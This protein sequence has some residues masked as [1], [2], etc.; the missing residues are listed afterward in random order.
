MKEGKKLKDTE[1]QEGET[2]LTGSL[3]QLFFS[4]LPHLIADVP[5]FLLWGEPHFE[6]NPLFKKLLPYTTRLIFQA[7]CVQAKRAKEMLDL[8]QQMPI[9]LVDLNWARLSA[10]RDVF[11]RVFDTKDQVRK[12]MAAESITIEYREPVVRATYLKGWLEAQAGLR[13]KVELKKSENT[14]IP[15][16]EIAKVICQLEPGVDI[17]MERKGQDSQV[18]IQTTLQEICKLPYM[19]PLLDFSSSLTFMK[20]LFYYPYGQHYKNTLGAIASHEAD[21]CQE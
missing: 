4:T 16:G 5:I 7:D 6:D 19:I 15:D 11:S 21:V 8:M 20:E 9:E 17:K 12:L 10:W 18:E 2:V 1:G 14:K 13:R 3:D